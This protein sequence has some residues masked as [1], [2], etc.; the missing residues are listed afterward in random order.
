MS[1]KIITNNWKRDQKIKASEMISI[2]KDTNYK[3][4]ELRYLI[5]GSVQGFCGDCLVFIEYIKYWSC[6]HNHWKPGCIG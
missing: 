3:T 4:N 6:V 5:V 1:M 2:L